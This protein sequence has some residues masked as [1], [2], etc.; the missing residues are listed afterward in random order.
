MAA[1]LI[2]EHTGRSPA[3]RRIGRQMG[4]RNRDT[5]RQIT[6]YKTY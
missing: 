5:D 4:S 3:E 1:T 6:I 2:K